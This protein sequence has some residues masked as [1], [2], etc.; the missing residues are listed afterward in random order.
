MAVRKPGYEPGGTEF[1]HGK[2]LMA[3]LERGYEPREYEVLHAQYRVD[4][5]EPESSENYL[6]IG[7][8]T[9]K[10]TT[11]PVREKGPAK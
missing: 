9:D 8:R 5:I 7:D 1:A 2:G 6:G 10:E 11:I 3:P 4:S